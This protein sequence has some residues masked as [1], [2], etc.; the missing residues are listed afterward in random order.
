MVT[1]LVRECEP[2]HSLQTFLDSPPGLLRVLVSSLAAE[3][4]L[5]DTST[6]VRWSYTCDPVWKSGVVVGLY[7]GQNRAS[8][9]RLMRHSSSPNEFAAKTL[10][11]HV[12]GQNV[13]CFDQ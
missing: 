4:I 10:K 1:S 12:P 11:Q 9:R 8:M 6:D 7:G 3:L 5:A 2:D 13:R